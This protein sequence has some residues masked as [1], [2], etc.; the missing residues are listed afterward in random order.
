MLKRYI[1]PYIQQ[2][3]S[4]FPVVLL[5]GARQVGKSTLAK[6]LLKEGLVDRYI[7]LDDLT[8]YTAASADPDGFLAQYEGSKI[9]I[10]EIQRVPD[11]MRAIKYKV[12]ENRE[13][14]RFLLTGSANILSYPGVTESLAGRMDIVGI[15]GLSLSELYERKQ[16]SSFIEDIFAVKKL[17]EL[18]ASWQKKINGAPK[19]NKQILGK[20]IFYGSFP[21]IAL[22]QQSSFNARWFS[23]Y[24]SAYIERDVYD[25]SRMLDIISF[26]K[27]LQLA[28]L[29]TGNL[30]N[31]KNLSVDVGI[32]QRT[33]A[34]YLEILTL[35]F[36][37]QLIQPWF[38][39]TS[40]RLIK[41]PKI[42]LRDSGF[43]CYL[44]GLS[45]PEDLLTHV[46]NGALFETWVCSELRK[47]LVTMPQ[48][49]LNFYR[50]HQG[51]EVDFVL[52]KG[53]Q[54]CGIEC[55]WAESVTEKD[56]AGLRDLQEANKGN[57]KGILL[58]TGQQVVA[59][60]D[61]LIAVPIQILF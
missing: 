9:A 5:N 7:T 45:Q 51:K 19:L 35:T 26:S 54:L 13:P 42:Y 15:E 10:D 31:I 41:T 32:D 3:L 55:K 48:I 36:Q 52:S 40:K 18:T 17:Q 20:Q 60:S 46:T 8:I 43:A 22:K 47:L 11:L 59:F 44:A 57:T 12:D 38:S 28:G 1:I 58:Y 27:L 6:Q 21:E 25:L 49:K 33:L 16:A 14:G 61:C 53:T 4:H 39:N 37:V 34:R 29:R 2:G 56:F 23:A 30:L 50:T 24:Q